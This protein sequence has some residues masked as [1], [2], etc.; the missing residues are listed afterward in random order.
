MDSSALGICIQCCV[1]E[2]ERGKEE[3]RERENNVLSI[4]KQ[5]HTDLML[6]III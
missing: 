2:R 5:W 6:Y 3:G 4:L 1:E